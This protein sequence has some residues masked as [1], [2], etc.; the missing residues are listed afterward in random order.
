L[1]LYFQFLTRRVYN[2]ITGVI[3]L[4]VILWQP[5]WK[6]RRYHVHRRMPVSN[7]WRLESLVNVVNTA[8]D[9][10]TNWYSTAFTTRSIGLFWLRFWQRYR[11][12]VETFDSNY[13]LESYLLCN[14]R[15]PYKPHFKEDTLYVWSVW[16]CDIKYIERNVNKRWLLNLKQNTNPAK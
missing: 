7:K 6:R 5:A 14:A 9:L 3:K 10:T 11:P 2:H 1:N 16:S 8:H 4:T 13:G 15:T 12:Y